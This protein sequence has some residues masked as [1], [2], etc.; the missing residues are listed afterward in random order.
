MIKIKLQQMNSKKI[1]NHTLK[2][3]KIYQNKNNILSKL[4]LSK[5][6]QQSYANIHYLQFFKIPI[7]NRM[8]IK[9]RFY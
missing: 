7:H 8:A 6:E 3:L 5:N 9:N 4:I 2:I 1:L